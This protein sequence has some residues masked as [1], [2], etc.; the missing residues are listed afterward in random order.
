M[1]PLTD[2]SG[3]GHHA[4][5]SADVEHGGTCIVVG[6]GAVGLCSVFAARRLG[7]ARIIVMGHHEDRLRL[8]TEFRVTETIAE[9][10]ESAIET[11]REMTYGGGSSVLECVGAASAMEASIEVCRPG[12]TI[13]YVGV[14]HGVDD[15]GLELYSMFGKNLTLRG[16]PPRFGPTP[17]T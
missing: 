5:V 10:R 11:A 9:R 13:G 15:E 17:T 12:G 4:A 7:A 16:V 14:P 6:D 2:V 1:L 8:A 3:T